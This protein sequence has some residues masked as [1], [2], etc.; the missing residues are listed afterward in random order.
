MRVL[1]IDGGG[2]RGLIPALVL[3]E[4][5]R[6]TGRR[7]ATLVDLI[8]GT[9][10]GGILA[11]ALAK[12]DPLPAAEIAGIYEQ[13]GPRIFDRGLIKTVTSVDGY[14]DE[15]Y[16][17]D[18]LVA[19]L[20][21]YLG[22]AKLGDATVPVFV[23]AYDIEAR[24]ALLLR[25]G[26]DGAIAMVDAAHAT[27]AAPSYFEPIR[28]AGRALVD[29]GVFAINP[30]MSAYAEVGGE[31]DVLASLGTGD[32]T[33]RL[34]LEDVRGW[35]R[36]AWAQPILDVVFDGSADAV[37]AQLSRLAGARYVR[38]QTRLDE[39]SDDFDDASADNLAALRRE[40]ER[41][42]AARSADID[43]LCAALTA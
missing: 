4:I 6:R 15:R 36:L 28:V 38:L 8:A 23:T 10:T 21:R 30:A 32:H 35:G 40:A 37:D 13:E 34:A 19:A 3:A 29:G 17:A 2:I 12:P 18:G 14:L 11:C 43:A 42:I 5:E 25:S 26:E 27:S 16:D 33:R 9:S 1:A 24:E 22:D 31:A 41:L 7:T 39:A 20:R